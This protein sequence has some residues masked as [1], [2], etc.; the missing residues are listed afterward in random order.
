MWSWLSYLPLIWDR[1]PLTGPRSLTPRLGLMY[2]GASLPSY[3]DMFSSFDSLESKVCAIFGSRR[4]LSL[5]NRYTAAWYLR[6][7]GTPHRASFMQCQL[8]AGKW[9]A[10]WLIWCK[11]ATNGLVIWQMFLATACRLA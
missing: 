5:P 6:S 10:T 9:V 8:P 4:K 3:S 1:S 2:L 11:T 7:L